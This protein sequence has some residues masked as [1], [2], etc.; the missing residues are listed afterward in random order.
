MESLSTG[1]RRTS[2][3]NC[4]QMARIL[5]LKGDPDA[6]RTLLAEAERLHAGKRQVARHDAVL[7][8]L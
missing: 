6:A 7:K 3:V 4:Y 5:A 2:S 1:E 8:R